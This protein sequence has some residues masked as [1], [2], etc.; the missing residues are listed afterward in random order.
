M[1]KG[2]FDP[3]AVPEGWFSNDAQAAG[4]F[5]ETYIDDAALPTPSAGINAS[6][7]RRGTAYAVNRTNQEQPN[8]NVTTA[9]SG[10][11]GSGSVGAFTVSFDKSL[12]GQSGTGAV[13]SLSILTSGIRATYSRRGSQQ[14]LSWTNQDQPVTGV[15]VGLTGV[16]GSGSIGTFS[17]DHVQALAGVSGTGAAGTLVGS[18]AAS[19]SGVAGTGGIGSLSSGVAAVHGV[20]VSYSRRG[21]ISAETWTNQEPGTSSAA[22]TGVSGTGSQGA[23]GVVRTVALTG[24]SGT[25][26]IG[27]LTASVAT[28]VTV[29]LTGVSGTGAIGT[30]SVLGAVHGVNYDYSR[31]GSISA[32][33]WTNQESQSVNQSAALTG[34][35][36][37]GAVGSFA[38]THTNALTGVAGTGSVGTLTPVVSGIPVTVG[39]TGVSG[40]GAIGTIYVVGAPHG[41]KVDYSRRGSISAVTWTNQEPATADVQ[42][43]LTGVSASG[44]VGSLGNERTVGLSGVAATT[45]VGSLIASSGPAFGVPLTGVSATGSVGTLGVNIVG[46]GVSAPLTGVSATGAVGTLTASVIAPGVTV[47]LTGVSGYGEVGRLTQVGGT[48]VVVDTNS[49][50]YEYLGHHQTPKQRKRER[51]RLGI[52]PQDI[53]KA[54]HKV[55]R[56]VVADS[57]ESDPIKQVQVDQ[58]Y[59]AQLL[60]DELR[61][62]W[63]QAVQDALT[64]Q[65]RIALAVQAQEQDDEDVLLLLL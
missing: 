44:A 55:A 24:V 28:N 39:L 30:V 43:S 32:V 38:V 53:A 15:S 41:V 1:T 62:Y 56:V 35:S 10:V 23:F 8:P 52:E 13:G 34:L 2:L 16:S 4:W 36:G 42:A 51:Q 26:A 47:G 31:R 21:S 50:G 25:G 27:T 7:S 64:Q 60:M 9:L 22:L 6:Y 58:A 11:S 20:S 3:S 65:I 63:S 59:Y 40:L 37:S 45:A 57:G 48:P 46:P 14:I 18:L 29:G 12:T 19:L 5:D 17:I 33:T 61:G 54:V 49:G